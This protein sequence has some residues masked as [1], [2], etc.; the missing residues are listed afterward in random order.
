MFIL[1]LL[2][3]HKISRRKLIGRRGS[4]WTPLKFLSH[5]KIVGILFEFHQWWIYWETSTDIEKIISYSQ[6]GIFV[7]KAEQKVTEIFSF[8]SPIFILD[9]D[10]REQI[11]MCSK[12]SQDFWLSEV[13]IV[14][15]KVV[16]P[17]VACL[18]VSS[19]NF[20]L[21]FHFPGNFQLHMPHW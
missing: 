19:V 18:N 9:L 10:Y 3:L 20:L 7:S 21:V 8:V 15:M 13:H 6:I 4:L 2:F 11:W 12:F 5:I 1:F 17:K 14:L 16:S